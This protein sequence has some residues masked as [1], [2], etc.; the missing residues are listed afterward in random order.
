M[1]SED[2]SRLIFSSVASLNS[3]AEGIPCL[4]LEIRSGAISRVIDWHKKDSEITAPILLA[5]ESIPS[6]CSTHLPMAELAGDDS[7]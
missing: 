7:A 1:E 2:I 5:Q 4:V 3:L 6:V